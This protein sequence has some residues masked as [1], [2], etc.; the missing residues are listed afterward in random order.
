[1]SGMAQEKAPSFLAELTQRVVLW[2]NFVARR[3]TN[4]F[5]F[6]QIWTLADATVEDIN[7][8]QWFRIVGKTS[9]TSQ[10]RKVWTMKNEKLFS[11]HRMPLP[12]SFCC[13]DDMGN[14]V[15]DILGNWKCKCL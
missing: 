10:L 5:L 11:I 8:Q 15:L 7:G 2:P 4:L 13:E 9:L 14:R 6:D 12:T 1:M 3:S